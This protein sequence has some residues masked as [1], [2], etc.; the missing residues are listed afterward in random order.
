WVYPRAMEPHR[1]FRCSPIR[2]SK[3]LR[4]LSRMVAC[5][6]CL[7]VFAPYISAFASEL[8]AGLSKIDITPAQPVRMAGYESRKDPSQGVHDPLGA[9]A[10]ALEHDGQH[11]VLV[12]LDSL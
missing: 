2:S 4:R 1:G 8:R 7:L 10:L 11:L 3:P 6:A 9:R 5:C 12:S